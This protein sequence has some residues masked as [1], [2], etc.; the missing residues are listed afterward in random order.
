MIIGYWLLYVYM[1]CLPHI[2]FIEC[3]QHCISVLSVLQPLRNPLPHPVHLHLVTHN[4]LVMS[5]IVLHTLRSP[6]E[7]TADGMAV[8]GAGVGGAWLIG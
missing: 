6:L 4:L 8:T 7:V 1:H 5:T 2:N 3:C